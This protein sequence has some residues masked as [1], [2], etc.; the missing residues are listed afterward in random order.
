MLPWQP[1]VT[2]NTVP[3]VLLCPA[4]IPVYWILK[5]ESRKIF[6]RNK[7]WFS[8]CHLFIQLKWMEG[9]PRS[10]QQNWKLKI[11]FKAEFNFQFSKK[12]KIEFLTTLFI[13]NIMG[14]GLNQKCTDPRKYFYNENFQIYG[15]LLVHMVKIF[16]FFVLWFVFSIIHGSGKAR[17]ME[18][19]WSHPSRA[20][21]QVD[22]K[23]L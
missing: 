20:W 5:F 23:M 10:N 17:K 2:N 13:P 8:L 14:I 18:K 9:W 15:T 7:N 12:L 22:A 1:H 21:H 19:A 4:I 3:K 6:I 11:D 16:P